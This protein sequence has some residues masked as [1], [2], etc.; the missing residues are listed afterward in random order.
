MDAHET[1]NPDQPARKERDKPDTT[2][3]PYISPLPVKSSALQRIVTFPGAGIEIVS[4]QS[5]TFQSGPSS[6]QLLLTTFVEHGK[7]NL[8]GGVGFDGARVEDGLA[9]ASAEK[10]TYFVYDVANSSRS[11]VSSRL[12]SL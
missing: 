1:D 4:R 6:P 7:P 12:V 2:S 10:S 5:P 9:F 8:F 3:L 11:S